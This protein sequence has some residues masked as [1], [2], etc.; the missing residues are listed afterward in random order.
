MNSLTGPK[1]RRRLILTAMM[2]GMAAFL[3]SYAFAELDIN[4]TLHTGLTYDVGPYSDIAESVFGGAT[5]YVDFTFEHLP[6]MLIPILGLGWLS[7][8]SGLSPY[9]VWPMAMT[10][11]FTLTAVLVD[12]ISPQRPAGFS[13]VAVSLPL[14]PLALFRLEPWVVLLAVGAIVAFLSTRNVAGIA[15]AILGSMAKGWPIVVSILPWKVGHRKVAVIAATGSG[16]ALLAVLTQ[17]GFRSGRAFDG[18]H[19]ETVVGGFLLFTRH[20]SGA[21]LDT[22]GSAGAHYVG[23]PTWAVIVN[24]IPGL[25]VLTIVGVLLKRPMST[26]TTV[27]V[28]GLSVLGIILVSPLF[29]TQFLV[30]LAPF[31]AA[32]STRN[33]VLYVLAGAFAFG[34]I[35]IF[36]PATVLWALEVSAANLI[37][38][39]LAASWCRDLITSTRNDQPTN[40]SLKNLPV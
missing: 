1:R 10:G 11:L 12:G 28:I 18:I 16:L 20:L 19:S 14:L 8:L 36:E 2:A 38:L 26:Q 6:A 23:A 34:S 5:P 17:E 39:V 13:F 37:I 21:A 22:F 7:D 4:G 35:A 9:F 27:S 3:L 25:V 33:R 29:S 30:W 40:T 32:L 31:V 24:A 15:L